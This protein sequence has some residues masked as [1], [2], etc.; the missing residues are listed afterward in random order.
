MHPSLGAT[1]PVGLRVAGLLFYSSIFPALPF[2][3]L[4]KTRR[5]KFTPTCRELI[6]A[7][8]NAMNVKQSRRASHMYMYMYMRRSDPQYFAWTD[9]EPS[10][11]LT[12]RFCSSV[13][14]PHPTHRMYPCLSC[15]HAPIGGNT[16]LV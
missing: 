10:K 14:R 5:S 6:G 13:R 3:F 12:G 1:A 8:S 9:I 7:F 15:I 4:P 16:I 11:L 2:T